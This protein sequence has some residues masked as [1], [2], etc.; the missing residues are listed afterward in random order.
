MYSP[1][2]S[3]FFLNPYAPGLNEGASATRKKQPWR[4]TVFSH[5]KN[6]EMARV[7]RYKVV[8]RDEGKGRGELYDLRVDHDEIQ[9]QYENPQFEDIRNSLSG[10][11]ANWRK[12]LV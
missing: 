3:L 5:Y 4:T 1:V 2:F 11:L 6:T 12:F 7:D 9:N 8:V 10:Q